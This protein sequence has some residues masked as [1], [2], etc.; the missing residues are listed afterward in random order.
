MAKL[1]EFVSKIKNDGLARTNRYVVGIFAPV[2]SPIM[3]LGERGW[4]RDALLMCDQVQ[5]PGTN[6]N[7]A[8]TRTFGEIRK[9]PYERLY[10]DINMSF[11][12]DTSM[13]VKLMFDNW[14]TYIQ[15]PGSRNFNYYDDYTADI[16]IEVQDLKNQS[17]Y[18]IKLFEAYPKS[19]GAIQ[20]DYAGKDVMKMSVNFAYKY[21]AIGAQEVVNTDAA[22]GGFS[23]YN[24]MGD[25]PSTY[26]PIFGKPI[27]VPQVKND[28][29]NN[30]VNR[31]KN[32]AIG[33]VGAK[34]VSKLPGILRR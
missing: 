16:V 9:A 30:F 28:P 33:A 15:N 25:S 7:T 21:Y 10:E 8:D 18:G 4:M 34:V 14:M 17:R 24:F 5:I 31:L 29:L 6:F 2:N 32:F 11:Y 27:S 19:I 1:N 12:V 23:P 20:M 3:N 26:N 22:D 13:T